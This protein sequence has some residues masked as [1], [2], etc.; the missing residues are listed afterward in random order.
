MSAYI[1]CSRLT[2]FGSFKKLIKAVAGVIIQVMIVQ[3][4]PTNNKAS[5]LSGLLLATICEK[6]SI[7]IS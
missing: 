3:N 1:S 4:K 5:L 6:H 2:N 7:E